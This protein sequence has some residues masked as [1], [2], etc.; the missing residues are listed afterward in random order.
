MMTIGVDP[1]KQTHTAAL[2]DEHTG[3]REL[4]SSAIFS[5]TY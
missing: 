4:P 1:H 3:R 2:I 5:T